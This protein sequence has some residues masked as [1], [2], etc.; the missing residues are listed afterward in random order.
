MKHRSVALFFVFCAI[1]FSVLW[2]LHS[3]LDQTTYDAIE[4]GMSE[5]EATALVPIAPGTIAFTSAAQLLAESGKTQFKD[6]EVLGTVVKTA[7]AGVFLYFD[8]TTKKELGKKRVWQTHEYSLAV[9]FSPDGKVMGKQLC[10]FKDPN[11]RWWH[12][13]DQRFWQFVAHRG[14]PGR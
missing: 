13:L 9:L 7:G 3:P 5:N 2:L 6:D 1:G 8:A 10:R 11:A 4:L 14:G 12:Y